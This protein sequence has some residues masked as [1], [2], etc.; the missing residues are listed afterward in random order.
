ME[1]LEVTQNMH[2][3]RS[4]RRILAGVRFGSTDHDKGLCNTNGEC[5]S[6][7]ILV[8]QGISQDFAEQEA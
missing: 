2:K 7:G 8:S 6:R 5:R 1:G 3:K 4:S